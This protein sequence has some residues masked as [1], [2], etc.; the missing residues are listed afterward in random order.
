MEAALIDRGELEDSLNLFTD[1][2]LTKIDTKNFLKL[3]DAGSLS[4]KDV[5]RILK[6]SRPKLYKREA[7]I[8]E[9]DV[10]TRLIPLVR[11]A[12]LSFEVYGGE[13]EEHKQ[14]A[15]NW[16]MAPNHLFFNSSPFQMALGGKADVVIEK[17]NEWL[18]PEEKK[19]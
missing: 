13:T 18:Q 9:E 19:D 7:L 5:A 17:L 1:S 8:T 3:S 12:D 16:I 6:I 10:K 2:A 15:R 4:K 11:I 14:K